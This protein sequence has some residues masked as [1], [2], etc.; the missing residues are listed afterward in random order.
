ME[1]VL[2]GTWKSSVTNTEPESSLP[3]PALHTVLVEASFM[4]LIFLTIFFKNSV[5]IFLTGKM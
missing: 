1:P 5:S 2:A 4:F 3:E